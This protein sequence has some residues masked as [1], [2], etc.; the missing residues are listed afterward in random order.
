MKHRILYITSSDS[1][2]CS[3]RMALA[4]QASE[5]GY[6][7]AVATVC[8]GL[9]EYI[10]QNG[11][12]VFSLNHYLKKASFSI[13]NIYRFLKELKKIY[14]TF[15]PNIVH[16][17]ALKITILGSFVA[18]FC[19]IPVV[20]NTLG[21]L[22]Y[23][24]TK[25]P[26]AAIFERCYKIF[27]RFIISGSLYF[28]GKKNNVFFIVQND[29]D[30]KFLEKF[31]PRI[32]LVPGSGVSIKKYPLTKLP[33]YP[34]IVVICVSRLLRE[35]GI[36]EFA[37]AAK[38]L[39]NKDVEFVL[40]GAPDPENPS[41]L[42]KEEINVWVNQGFIKWEGFCSDVAKAYRTAHIAVLPSYREGFPKSLLEAASCGRP[43][44]TT[45]IPGCNDMV[46]NEKNGLLV[47][48]G[49]GRALAEAIK[50]LAQNPELMCQMG[51]AGRKRVETFFSDT[52]I[53]LATLKLYKK[54]YPVPM[55][56][57]KF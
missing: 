45:D 11:I 1:Y 57:Q 21:G 29:E 6:E 43:I 23:I 31:S 14:H 40:Y 20:V 38:I 56:S 46:I 18:I 5:E 50:R 35:K 51:Q 42:T 16:H 44:V 24:F 8:S 34:P 7:V 39:N 12:R 13:L 30:M 32:H 48:V 22:G 27:L 4:K 33:P 15:K 28:L 10:Q 37:E 3:H 36:Y 52:I 25:N 9:K 41:S 47:P 17:I 53:N 2:F 54:L 19:K 49:D 55:I 26:K